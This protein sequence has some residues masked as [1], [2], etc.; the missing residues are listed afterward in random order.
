MVVLSPAKCFQVETL[1]CGKYISAEEFLIF[2]CFVELYFITVE[3]AKCLR[4]KML[5]FVLCDKIFLKYLKPICPVLKPANQWF[6][7][8]LMSYQFLSVPKWS[9]YSSYTLKIFVMTCWHTVRVTDFCWD[10]FV[11]DCGTTNPL[12]VQHVSMTA[13]KL[14][15]VKIFG[16][17]INF[18]AIGSPTLAKVYGAPSRCTQ[19]G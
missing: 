6:F 7:F 5:S 9:H 8:K 1:L 15:A 18:E 16:R 13:G 3:A 2:L 14:K 19:G 4:P 17:E 11:D 12:S 10:K